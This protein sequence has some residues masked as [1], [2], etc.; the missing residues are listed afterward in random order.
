MMSNSGFS[1][2]A[3]VEAFTRELRIVAD[4]RDQLACKLDL[5]A[6]RWNTSGLKRDELAALSRELKAFAQLCHSLCECLSGGAE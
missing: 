2:V 1:N 4:W 6:L 3:E 5:A